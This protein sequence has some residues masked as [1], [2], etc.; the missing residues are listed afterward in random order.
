[1]K[2]IKLIS[3][4]LKGCAVLVFAEILCLFIDLTLAFSGSVMF[5]I[6]SVFCTSVIFI[7]LICNYA[8]NTAKNDL[9]I[10]RRMDI[11]L[12][13]YRCFA[14]GGFLSLPYI[15]LWVIL[16]LSKNGVIGNFYKAYKLINGQF[17]Q[18][19]NLMNSGTDAGSLSLSALIIMLL[20]TFVPFASFIIA[21]QLTF[22][23]VDVES[24]QY[25]NK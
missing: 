6:I 2:N 8:Y 7:G 3:V 25:K 12:P 19:Y 13:A 1:M 9:A 14:S 17:L 5:K 4:M 23:G 20:L 18:L 22:K 24:I 15:V 21:Y 16:I 10:Q 11:K